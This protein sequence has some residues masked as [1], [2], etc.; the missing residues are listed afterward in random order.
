M[1]RAAF[2]LIECLVA[3]A[4]IALLAALVFPALGRSKGM[5]R[6]TKCISNLRQI[7]AGLFIYLGENERYPTNLASLERHVSI[8]RGSWRDRGV[9]L[10]PDNAYY[11]RERTAARQG[12]IIVLVPTN[13]FHSDYHPNVFGSGGGNRSPLWGCTGKKENEIRKAEDMIFAG[14]ISPG[15]IFFRPDLSPFLSRTS[16]QWHE[17]RHQAGANSLFCD[18]HVE[19]GKKT[20]LELPIAEIRRRWNFDNEEHPES[21]NPAY[22]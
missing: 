7:G 1:K 13:E 20:K 10:C 21:W 3:V 22:R 16:V 17:F 6:R 19:H 11:E 14:D 9:F 12:L 8:D 4:V 2:T 18:G 15:I 5:A